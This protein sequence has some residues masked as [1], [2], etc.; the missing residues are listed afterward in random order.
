MNNLEN[1]VLNWSKVRKGLAGVLAST[2]LFITPVQ[3]DLK[4]EEIY[5]NED[6][7]KWPGK[8]SA[9]CLNIEDFG[10]KYKEK[11]EWNNSKGDYE[12]IRNTKIYLETYVKIDYHNTI[13]KDGKV[14]SS[15]RGRFIVALYLNGKVIEVK[16]ISNIR[17]D[18]IDVVE[19]LFHDIRL[20]RLNE[21]HLRDGWPTEIQKQSKIGLILYVKLCKG[22]EY[23]LKN[24]IENFLKE[25][26]Y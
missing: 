23:K 4:K 3:G 25:R 26:L 6:V 18:R 19:D 9:N 5:R 20:L 21:Q 8:S 2:L 14:E 22:A 11:F 10:A 15:P 12:E 1:N 7:T 17:H 16:D 13:D 24:Y